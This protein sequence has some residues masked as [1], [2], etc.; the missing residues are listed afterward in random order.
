MIYMRLNF[1]L[2]KYN[3]YKSIIYK[4]FFY[5]LMTTFF[6][7]SCTNEEE[8]DTSLFIT[9]NINYN[10]SLIFNNNITIYN[11]YKD[12]NFLLSNVNKERLKNH[13]KRVCLREIYI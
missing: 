10:D 13:P 12:I 6:L 5:L 4:D 2:K 9:N 7:K 1:F 11:P 8:W 3:L